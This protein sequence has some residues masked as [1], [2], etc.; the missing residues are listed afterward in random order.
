MNS[1]PKA[2]LVSILMAGISVPSDVPEADMKTCV[3]IDGHV[4]IQTLGKPHGCQI[5]GNYADVF[6]RT[7]TNHFG[8]HTTRVDVVFD[9][10]TGDESI[11]AVTRAKRMGKKKPI[12]K[13]I[14][15]PD[16]PLPQVWSNFIASDANKADLARFLSEMIMQKGEDLPERCEVVTGG[17]FSNATDARSTRRETVRLHGNHEEADTRLILHSCEAVSEGYE[18]LVVMCSDTDVLLLLLHFMPTRAAQVWM[19]SG[20]SKKRKCYPIH[21]VSDKLPQPVR[22]NLLSFHALTGCDTTSAFSGHGKKTCWKTFQSQPLL[23]SGIGRDGE[24]AQVEQ[25]V[26]HLYGV[27]AQPSVDQA[28]FHVFGKAKKGLDLLPPTRDALDLHSKRANYQAKIWLQ[29]DRE[30][31]RIPSPV[32]TAAWVKEKTCLVPIWTRLPPIPDACLQL[33]TC[34]CKSKCQT[35]RCTCFKKEL[36]CTSACGCDAGECCN[37]ELG[38]RFSIKH[39][40]ST[41]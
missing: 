5:F 17:G 11:K 33:M 4:L 1:T 21:A 16:V 6:M 3:L 2:E 7:A 40:H 39:A 19:V 18:R 37:P 28:R 36:K 13:I 12:R 27:P 25:F 34:G 35:A 8:E 10:Y 38:N 26:C 22:E 23:V 15:G 41:F 20:T 14:D 30:C 31:I 24:L 32:D 29:A 9:R